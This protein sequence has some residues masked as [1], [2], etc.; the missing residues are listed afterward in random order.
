[1]GDTYV[2]DAKAPTCTEE[3]YTGDTY[4]A[5]CDA[6]LTKGEAIPATGHNWGE[7]ETVTPATCE[8]NG[9]EQRVCRNDS[10]HVQENILTATGHN[11]GDWLTVILPT[12]EGEGLERRI[13]RNDPSHVEENTLPATGHDYHL[14]EEK[15]LA[16]DY[17]VGGYDYYECANDPAHY[18]TVSIPALVKA[19]YTVTF[20]AEGEVVAVV[21][22]EEGDKFVKEPTAPEKDNYTVEWEEYELN[23]TNITVNAI[24]TPIDP[25]NVSEIETD[26]T[27]DAF[28]DGLATITLSAA[29]A[30]RVIKLES[31]STKPVDVILVLD[32]SGSMDESLGRRGDTKLEALQDCATSFIESLNANAVATGADHRVALVSFASADKRY[33]VSRWENTGLLVTGESGFVRYPNAAGYYDAAFMPT[34]DAFGVNRTLINAINNTK[35]NGATCTHLGLLMAKNILAQ[36]GAD[37]REK[38]VVLITDG[39]PTIGGTVESEIAAAAPP[40][41]TYANDIKNMGVKLYTV[42][43]EANADADQSFTSAPDGITGSGSRVSFDFNRF[44]HLVSSNYPDAE[45]MNHY[46]EK[47]NDGYYMPVNDTA[48]LNDIFTKI[49]VSSVYQKL[50]FTRCTLVDTLSADFVLTMEQE[51]AL[52]ESLIAT[53]NLTNEDISV[54]RNEDGTTT[55]R[56][57]NVP[58]VKTEV[59]GKTVYRAAV[60]FDCSLKATEKGSYETNTDEA[61]VEVGGEKVEDFEKPE[62]VTVESDRNIVVFTIGGEIYRIE[63]GQ[64]GDTVVAPVTDLAQWSIPEGTVIEGSYAVFEAQSLSQQMHT[65]TWKIGEDTLVETYRFGEKITPPAVADQGELVFSGFSPAVPHIMP[66]YDMTFTAL[67]APRHEHFFKQT[68]FYGTCTEG[69]TIVNTCACGATREEKQA[70]SN[71]QFKAI[72]GTVDSNKLT[73]TLVCDFCGASEG[74]TLS[75]QTVTTAGRRTTIADLNLEKNGVL[76]QPTEGSS[77]KIMVPWSGRRSRV[78]VKRVNEQGVA[79]TYDASIENGYLVFY[80]DHFSIYVLEELD[81]NNVSYEP[82]SYESALCTLA[83]AHQYEQSETAPT[84]TT[85]GSNTYTCT[86]CGDTYSETI[87]M[88]GHTDQDGD[89]VCDTCGAILEGHPDLCVYCGQLHTGFFGWIVKFFH[90][91]LWIFQLI[92]A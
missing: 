56:I 40:A 15:S 69:L 81:E 45:A 6:L 79:Q 13:C 91:I 83:G 48:A 87:P 89:K 74:H 70:P 2:K 9:L 29:A 43:V 30:T 25:D 53:Y 52:R 67:F 54:Q 46:G 36:T 66:N 80:A 68:G 5:D 60:T 42:G 88:T 23:D 19:T 32:L 24:Y 72:I 51:N 86:V 76:I 33:N 20:V 21:T 57:E 55:L 62:A 34:G 39:N 8:K 3:G 84:C 65:V 14:N 12:C 90:Y 61:W 44:L 26:K 49:L 82:I 17:G 1:M 11:W 10:S 78:S 4:C 7:W 28:E 92:F 18:Y 73:D 75:F 16:P 50:V 63:E 22:Y 77:I 41:I 31:V 27:V 47:V 71:H 37:G 35:A 85:D 64:L 38:V 58:A 59:D